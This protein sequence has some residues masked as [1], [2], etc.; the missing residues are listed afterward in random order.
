MLV[1]NIT[2]LSKLNLGSII[3]PLSFSMERTS[4]GFPPKV[5]INSEEIFG[6]MSVFKP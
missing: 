6:P 3:I 5:A 4:H 1:I 2:V